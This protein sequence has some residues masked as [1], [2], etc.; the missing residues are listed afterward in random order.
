[1]LGQTCCAE[2]TENHESLK[3]VNHNP[4]RESRVAI[5]VMVTRLFYFGPIGTNGKGCVRYHNSRRRRQD[6]WHSEISRQLIIGHA[7]C[8]TSGNLKIR[9]GFR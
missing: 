7:Y 5:V 6:G 8:F 2:G 4:L 9:I 3:G 1:M